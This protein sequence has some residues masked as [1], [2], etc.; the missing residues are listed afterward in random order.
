MAFLIPIIGFVFF[1]EGLTT[2]IQILSKKLRNGKKVFLSAPYHHHLEALG[3]PEPKIVMRIWVISG[4]F[5]VFGIIIYLL[6]TTY[7]V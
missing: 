6:D 2:I 3:W 4:V 1:W 5:S 7:V